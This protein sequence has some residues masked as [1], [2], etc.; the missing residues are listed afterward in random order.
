M[1]TAAAPR[2]RE[3]AREPTRALDRPLASYYLVLGSTAL[4]VLLGLVMVLSASSVESYVQT[5][6]SFT[7]FQRQAMWVAVA[8][9]LMWAAS[10]LP[11]RFYRRMAPIG[12]LAALALLAL[13]PLVGV[14]VKGNRNWLDLAG[15]RM[16]PSE[17]AKLALIVWGAD[18]LARK[19][20]LLSQW[21]H[22][23]VP[24]VPVSV[25]VLALVMLGNDLGTVLVIMAIV[26]ALLFLVG[27]PL[28]LFAGSLLAFGT[29][30]ALLVV[31]SP[32][33]MKRLG[34]WR[35]PSQDYLDAGWQAVHGHYALATGGWWGLGLGASRQKW[36]ALPEAHTDFIFAIIGEEL[37]LIG[38]LT[39]LLLFIA[40]A[41]GGFR[42]AVRSN[43]L[44]VR[45]AAGGVTAWIM[46]QAVVNI[47][48]VLGLLP[49]VGV[50]L[51][52]V[53]YGGSS[54][55]TVLLGLGMLLS[56]ARSTPEAAAV[57]RSR[58]APLRRLAR[59]G[60]R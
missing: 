48:A 34:S 4:L 28:R 43:D 24:L 2:L 14:E 36:G 12:L 15:M 20:R 17:L 52:L 33:R 10:R 31:S 32:N 5:K 45:L 25:L 8:L 54:L 41:Y 19:H 60:R 55:I 40:L 29:I 7:I 3:A 42:V 6:S 9:P 58:P 59:Q 56:F 37:G 22:L 44:F 1:T 26:G 30:V 35:T 38:T 13:V 11:V 49:I 16:Q 27:A 51:P 47:G 53:S 23:L 18:L 46:I 57:L 21:K 50:S 39:V